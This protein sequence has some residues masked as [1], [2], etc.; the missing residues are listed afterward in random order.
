MSFSDTDI[1]R[2]YTEGLSMD[3]IAEKG[4]IGKATVWRK[5]HKAGV[6][7]RKENAPL[8]EQEIARYWAEHDENLYATAKHF[9][10][11]RHSI[12]RALKRAGVYRP[13]PSY[14]AKDSLSSVHKSRDAE[15]RKNVM[16]LVHEGVPKEEI[17]R[18]L[19]T[20]T[21]TVRHVI[22]L[23]QNHITTEVNE[24]CPPE[25][26]AQQKSRKPKTSSKPK[27]QRATKSDSATSS[28]STHDATSPESQG[29]TT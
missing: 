1:V 8:D 15:F 25:R 18:R 5:L 17:C 7:I 19:G 26:K 13:A 9:D 24:P 16:A 22:Y 28:P 6:P 27:R 21:E 14:F 11:T 3:Q 4:E 2:L 20:T 10:K 29:L 12:R 23:D